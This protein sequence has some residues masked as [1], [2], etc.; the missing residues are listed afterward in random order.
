MM[1][2]L[3]IL[4]Q[5]YGKMHGHFNVPKS[6]DKA[7]PHYALGAWHNLQRSMKRSFEAGKPDPRITKERIDRLTLELTPRLGVELEEHVGESICGAG[8]I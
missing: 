6:K 2:D 7:A 4:P 1:Y 8:G 3:A 5:A